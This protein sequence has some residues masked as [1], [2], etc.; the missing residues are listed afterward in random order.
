M[1]VRKRGGAR[2]FSVSI[3]NPE[4]LKWMNEHSES[5]P[6]LS[7]VLNDSLVEKKKEWDIIHSENPKILHDKIESLKKV[8]S[9]FQ[10]FHCELNLETKFFEWKE[11]NDTKIKIEKRPIETIE[12]KGSEQPSNSEI[13]KELEVVI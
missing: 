7:R 4:I 13:K 11:K 9:E 3:S 5:V 10:T 12:I 1:R 8:I 2:I 6:S